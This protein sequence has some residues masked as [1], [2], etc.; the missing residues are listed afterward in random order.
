MTGNMNLG[1]RVS[2]LEKG[3]GADI[4]KEISNLQD[5]V[6]KAQSDIDALETKVNSGHVYSTDEKVVGKWLDGRSIYE[7]TW[8]VDNVAVNT[9][10]DVTNTDFENIS[11]VTSASLYD[12]DSENPRFVSVSTRKLTSTSIRFYTNSDW[13][14][15]DAYTLQYV[16]TQ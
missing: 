2:V 1:K 8:K 9:N 7:K 12:T 13:A 5:A 14:S 3:G 15:I 6:T 4:K 11:F 16:K 10:W